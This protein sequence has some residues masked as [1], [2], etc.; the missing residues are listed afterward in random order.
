CLQP[1]YARTMR[2]ERFCYLPLFVSGALVLV[3]LPEGV[4]VGAGASPDFPPVVP[5]TPTGPAP[6]GICCSLPAFG[7]SVVGRRPVSVLNSGFFS[8]GWP[9]PV[10]SSPTGPAHRGICRRFPACFFP[11]R[12]L[13]VLVEAE[14]FPASVFCASAFWAS[15]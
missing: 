15:L 11:L 7:C 9:L 2:A 3:S 10:P 12:C 4:S 8:V 1:G 5:S 13:L 6:R 14:S